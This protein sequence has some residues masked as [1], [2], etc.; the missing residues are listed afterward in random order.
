MFSKELIEGVNGIL[1]SSSGVEA[2]RFCSCVFP[3]DKGFDKLATVLS[4]SQT[5]ETLEFSDCGLTNRLTSSIKKIISG[6]AKR[7]DENLWLRDEQDRASETN[8]KGLLKLVLAKNSLTDQ[9]VSD[10]LPVLNY[11]QYL[12]ALDL[13]D[14][15]IKVNGIINLLGWLHTARNVVNLDLREN[16][17]YTDAIHKQLMR[18]LIRNIK[19]TKKDKVELRKMIRKGFISKELLANCEGNGIEEHKQSSSQKKFHKRKAKKRNIPLRKTVTEEVKIV[20]EPVVHE[21]AKAQVKMGL[22]EDY[23]SI[24]CTDD[25]ATRTDIFI[26]YCRNAL[27]N[28]HEILQRTYAS[29][30]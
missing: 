9:F 5:L 20:K 24:S 2:L 16:P 18:E 12:R 1:K 21:E 25:I 4:L 11:D 17:G 22:A 3:G 28:V 26:S 7:R 29:R 13:S 6:H 27:Q 14:N 23:K 19:R 10:V 15:C 30:E 8:I